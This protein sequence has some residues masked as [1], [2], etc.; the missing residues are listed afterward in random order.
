MKCLSAGLR[1]SFRCAVIHSA[2]RGKSSI[3]LYTTSRLN[4]RLA[5]VGTTAIP[6]PADTRP[7]TIW[8]SV[9]SWAM[10]GINPAFSHKK[11]NSVYKE[12]HA[13]LAMTISDSSSR[14]FKCTRAFSV[15]GWCFG[16]ART[17]WLFLPCMTSVRRFPT[18]DAAPRCQ[19]ARLAV[20]RSDWGLKAP[21]DRSARTGTGFGIP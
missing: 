16:S 19:Y 18:G 1:L 4:N 10:L 11:L 20:H 21:E 2:R 15:N 5:A 6:I 3:S 9:A 17:Q 7:I 13:S 12:G 8:Y 14:S